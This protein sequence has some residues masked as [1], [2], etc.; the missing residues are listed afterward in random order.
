M[1][2][3]TRP[4]EKIC[5]SCQNSFKVCPPGKTSRYYPKH[6]Q[7][8]CSRDCACKG[9]WRISFTCNDLTPT[10][11][12]YVAGFLDGE[13]SIFLYLRSDAVNL[14]VAFSNSDKDCLETLRE[15]FGV[16]NIVSRSRNSHKHKTGHILIINGR[17]GAS[18]LEQIEPYLIIKLEQARLGIDFIHKIKEP[19][20]KADRSWQYEYRLRIKALN[21]TGP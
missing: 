9:R 10:Q 7:V 8:F 17:A 11:T 15:W 13:G 16:G 4:I 20:L 3:Q 1:R 21:K 5:P 2:Q 14:R 18:L 6:T 12:A 19:S